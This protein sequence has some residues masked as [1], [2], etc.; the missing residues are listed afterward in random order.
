[1]TIPRK[2]IPGSV[3]GT[4]ATTYYTA[5]AN[6]RCLIKKLTFT[7]VSSAA[8]L[9]T[10]YLV[11]SGGAAGDAN[12]IRKQKTVAPL[13]VFECFEAENQVV[14]AGGFIQALADVA[15]DIT[16]QGSGIELT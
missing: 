3:L 10:V 9:V 8:V 2:I 7:N 14:E 6:T 15:S 1:M 12:T 16:I 11:P 5:P 4:G 13:D